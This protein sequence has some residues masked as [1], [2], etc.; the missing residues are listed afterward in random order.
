ML[1]SFSSFPSSAAPAAA[2]AAAAP[3]SLLSLKDLSAGE[4]TALLDSADA[5]KALYRPHK[6]GFSEFSEKGPPRPLEG[7]SM[8][9]IF[10]KRSTRTRVSTETGFSMMGGHAL[11]LGSEDIQL[12][13]NESMTDT[14]RV[15]S[16]FNSVILARVFAHADVEELAREASVPVINALS[17]VPPAAD[18]G[19]PADAART[20]WWGDG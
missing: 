19:R 5:L 1:S 16:R 17:E 4:I 14:A 3:R 7:K 10:Q 13:T 2:P 11:F 6:N 20:P 9:M 8:A 12:G 18:P 15:L